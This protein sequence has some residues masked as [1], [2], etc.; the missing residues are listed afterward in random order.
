LTSQTIT[1]GNTTYTFNVTVNG[2]AVVEPNETFF[3]NVTSV[4]NAT[5]TDGQGQGTITNDDSAATPGAIVISQV[6][7]GGGNAG[8]PF[9]NDFIELFNRGGTAVDVTGWSVQYIAATGAGS[10]TVTPICPSGPCLIQPGQYFL[11]K[12]SS[13]GATGAAFTADVT[14]TIVMATGAGRVAVVNNITA[15]SGAVCGTQLSG[16]IDYVGYGA[17]ANCFEGAGPTPAPSN[18]SSVSRGANGCTDTNVN[19]ADFA[20]GAPN[21]RNTST[22]T[23]QCPGTIVPPE[24]PATSQWRGGLFDVFE[25]I[26]IRNSLYRIL[27]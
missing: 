15:L 25:S 6:Y 3:V 14:G 26:L 8:A 7:G 18:T 20:A 1:A 4:T 27:R 24:N 12:E 10:F 11:I 16:A 23:S 22:P 21:P 19:S 9:L 13:G 2:D 17:T 5:V